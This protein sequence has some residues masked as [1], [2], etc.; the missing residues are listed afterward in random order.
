MI[1]CKY[2]LTALG[3]DLKLFEHVTKADDGPLKCTT[4]PMVD[5]GTYEI[6]Y[7]NTEKST[8][9]ESFYECSS[10]RGK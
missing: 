5:L 1:L 9:E 4:Y 6:K 7:L 2:I 8:P 3:I 10:R